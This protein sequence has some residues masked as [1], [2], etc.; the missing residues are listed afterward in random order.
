MTDLRPP[1][2][3]DLDLIARMTAPVPAAE[4]KRIVVAMSGGVDSSV[5]ACLLHAQ[6]H[7]VIGMTMQL[8][9]HGAAVQKKGACCAGQDIHDARRVAERAGFPHY[10][11]DYED[12][13]REAVIEDFA[14]SYLRGETPI[15]CVAC[16]QQVKFKDLLATSADL[17]ADY[18]ATGHYIVREETD[19]GPVLRCGRDVARDQSYF[20]FGTTREQ[21]ATLLFPIG[22]LTKPDVRALAR[23]F[24]L[25]IADK[26]DSQDI[27]FVPSGRYAETIERL[28][29][30]ASEPGA[31]VHVDGQTLGQHNG[32]IHFTV[33]QRR[34]LGIATGEP[35]FVVAI[36]AEAKRVIVGPKSALSTAGLELRDVNWLGDG[37][38]AENADREIWVKVRS[39]GQPEPARLTGTGEQTA[40]VELIKSNL[41]IAR[42]QACVFYERDS[43]GAR[44]LGGGFIDKTV[45]G[46]EAARRR[47]DDATKEPGTSGTVVAMST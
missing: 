4:R 16:N 27:C 9:D 31:I 32:I 26:P 30:G 10:V 13:F 45:A 24:G 25:A 1:E 39:T 35:L 23:H 5:V 44:I 18:L 17:E 8:Y 14:A 28:K 42:G 12:R 2:T 47:Q 34:G 11:L 36:E 7:D 19:G 38:L 29:P 41:G 21:L 33:G 20:L 43:V 40:R 46:A 15:P 6:G 37:R 22:H 3:T